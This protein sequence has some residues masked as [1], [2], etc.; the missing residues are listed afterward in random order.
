LALQPS[1]S[2][3]PLTSY[4]TAFNFNLEALRGVAAV[5][6]VWHHVIYHQRQL[7][8]VY[9]PTGIGA[10]NPPGHFAVFIF[11][12]L[13]GY[14]IGKSHPEPLKGRG[15]LTYLRKR[16]VRLYPIYVVAVLA[17]AAVSGFTLPLRTILQHLYFWQSWGDPVMFENNP[18]WSLQYEV[19]FYL[20][21]IP[22]SI[23]AVRPWVV[24]LV[25]SVA[26]IS[27]LFMP[28]VSYNAVIAQYLIGFSFWAVGWAFSTLPTDTQPTPWPR[29]VSSLL[30]LLSIEHFNTLT[31]VVSHGLTW[32]ATHQVNMSTAWVMDYPYLPYAAMIVL[33]MAGIRN[34]FIRVVAL[35]LQLLPLYGVAYIIQH[36]PEPGI[37]ELMIPFWLYLMSLVLYFTTSPAVSAASRFVIQRLIPLGA[38]SYGIYVI[39]FPI[40]F[41]FGQVK[42]FSGSPTTFMVRAALYLPLV[43]LAATLLDKKFQPWIKR[44]LG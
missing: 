23:L 39:H 6:V 38:I 28:S 11:F 30:L 27:L 36:W 31:V 16:F 4:S 8:P 9:I 20:A 44:R 26:G 21:F 2:P 33:C 22:L 14:V 1:S 13:S 40:I 29:L 10:Y 37:K 5:V 35:I 15:I 19:L 24:A 7:D 42:A 32:L 12:L 43:F 41:L 18:L 34:P 3:K 17:G 25:A